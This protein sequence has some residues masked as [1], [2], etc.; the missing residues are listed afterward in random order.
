[1]PR[2]GSYYSPAKYSGSWKNLHN[3][4]DT[5]FSSHIKT[6]AEEDA[7]YEE[8][9][10]RQA[11]EASE[12]NDAR[13]AQQSSRIMPEL[14]PLPPPQNVGYG[15]GKRRSKSSNKPKKSAKRVKTAKRSKSR[16][17]RRRHK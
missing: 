17:I 4:L 14:R 2:S 16:K 13:R 3:Q 15:G 12:A 5:Q 9:Q 7:E 1:M 10:R 8:E 6:E 11:S